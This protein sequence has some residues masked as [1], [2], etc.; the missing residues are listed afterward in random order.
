MSQLELKD[1]QASPNQAELYDRLR[2]VRKPELH[3]HFRGCLRPHILHQIMLPLKDKPAYQQHGLLH[4]FPAPVQ[5]MIR[6]SA[7]VSQFIHTWQQTTDPQDLLTLCQELWQF[8]Q[9]Y[10]FFMSYLMTAGMVDEPQDLEPL[11][12]HVLAYLATH[13][14]VYAEIILSV[15]EYMMCGWTPA[16]IAE[17]CSRAEAGAHAQGSTI[18]W[19]FD[20]VRNFDQ[21]ESIQRLQQ[22]LDVKIPGWVAITLGGEEAKYPARDFQQLYEL[23][24]HHQLQLTCH[25]GEHAPHTSILE[26]VDLLKCVR[27]GHGVTAVESR[28]TMDRL[29]RGDV[30]VEMCPTSNVYTQALTHLKDHPIKAMM[31]HGIPIT[32]ASDDPGFFNTSLTKELYAC[33]TELGLDWTEILTTINQGFHAAFSPLEHELHQ[34]PA[35]KR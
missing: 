16:M 27:I 10:D 17:L 6:D 11:I 20:F 25:A 1:L 35:T 9:A 31:H 26:A 32:I 28:T 8:P 30:T 18:K 29:R 4:K 19:I 22:L 33:M 24:A 23:A 14:I 5:T 3:L 13:N 12:Q 7:H 34:L 21:A 15:S 2:Q